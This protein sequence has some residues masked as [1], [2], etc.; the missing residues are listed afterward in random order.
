MYLSAN[1]PEIR[2]VA[3]L[4]CITASYIRDPVLPTEHRD[5]I[6]LEDVGRKHDG[7]SKLD[8]VEL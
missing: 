1:E 5:S 3:F 2:W 8:N 4:L 6:D 7:E